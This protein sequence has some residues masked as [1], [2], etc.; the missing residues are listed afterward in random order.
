MRDVR[1]S[2][3][4]SDG[5]PAIYPRL[6]R[7]RAILPKVQFAIRYFETMLGRE[8]REIDSEI[9][10]HF[11][12][13]H[14]LARCM[15]ACLARSYR[16]RAREV[17]EVVSRAAMR[18]LERLDLASAR[19]LRLHLYDAVNQCAD[20]F[21]GAEAR[22]ITFSAMEDD[23]RLRA[24]EL[25][26]LL[27]L[28]ADEHAVLVRIGV[29]PR[30]IDVVAQYNFAVLETVLRH[31]ERIELS[32][33]GWDASERAAVDELM[34]AHG[35]DARVGAREL[36]L[37]GR[38]DAMGLWSRHGRRVARALVRLLEHDRANVLN[39]SA[40]VIV[41]DRALALAITPELLDVLGGVPAPSAGFSDADGWSQADVAAR[42]LAPRAPAPGTLVRRAPDPMAWASGVLTPDLLVQVER[43][44]ALV[45]LSRSP[46]HG[47]RLA[48][49]ARGATG[50]E[51]L[52]FVGDAESVAPLAAVG[53]TTAPMPVLDVGAVVAAVR[54]MSQVGNAVAGAA[55]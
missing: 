10:V 5:D 31:A 25:D 55:A 48:Q 15:V 43:E 14:K 9:L 7:D 12:A 26:R 1:F 52:L 30:P 19:A 17:H 46:A 38:Q 35:V 13:D 29:E 11:F 32:I 51:P 2:T 21:L 47:A 34:R 23:L 28:D 49:V 36:V 41:R 3:R 45:C 40:R 50:G 42:L 24:G 27:T 54:A 20:G 16:F 4:R 22:A 6:M 33:A 53:A 18:R 39:G 8:R 44:R 37:G